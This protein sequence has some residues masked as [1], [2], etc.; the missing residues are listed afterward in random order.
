MSDLINKLGK[1]IEEFDIKSFEYNLESH[2]KQIIELK[3]NVLNEIM[4]KCLGI[5][6][7]AFPN[8]C[9]F[10]ELFMHKLGLSELKY[11][12]C[13]ESSKPIVGMYLTNG[14]KFSHSSVFFLFRCNDLNL[15][16]QVME[17]KLLDS[18]T[19]CENWHLMFVTSYQERFFNPHFTNTFEGFMVKYILICKLKCSL[20]YRRSC[21]TWFAGSMHLYTDEYFLQNEEKRL[22]YALFKIFEALILNGLLR[23]IEYHSLIKMLKRRNEEI[24]QSLS[25][26][27][28]FANQSNLNLEKFTNFNFPSLDSIFP[29]SLKSMCRIAI[30]RSLKN[31]TNFNIQQLYLPESLK[32]FVFFEDEC[33]GLYQN[34]DRYSNM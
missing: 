6:T 10:L 20:S 7:S 2:I 33:L 16:K 1:C 13:D 29:L 31:Y 34:F 25:Q 30:K 22:K 24:L 11:I 4:T 15:V 3:P 28:L 27:N 23:K 21:L 18:L 14:R 8:G 17:S 26:K 5:G 19:T 12:T 32:R 9:D